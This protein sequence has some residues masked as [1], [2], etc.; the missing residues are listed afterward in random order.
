MIYQSHNYQKRRNAFVMLLF[1]LVMPC[2]IGMLALIVDGGLAMNNQRRLQNVA[3][4]I[5]TSVANRYVRGST[6]AQCIAAANE[7]RSV[8]YPNSNTFAWNA[9]TNN[10]VNN[11]PISGPY[12]GNAKFIEVVVTA[13]YPGIL[14]SIFSRTASTIKARAV[15][16]MESHVTGEGVITLDPCLRPGLEV[17][18]GS[19]LIVAGA[20][21]CNSG[22][23]GYDQNN[24][25]TDLG[26][27]QYSASVA[28]NGTMKCELAL[29][30]G[31]V[32]T[33]SNFQNYTD[34]APNPLYANIRSI[35]PDPYRLLPIPKPANTPSITNWNTSKKVA[36]STGQTATLTPGIYEDISITGSANVTFSPGTYIMV[37]KTPNQGLRINGSPTV[38]G[39]NVFFYFT[40]SNYL[41]TSPGYWDTL[42]GPVD[43]PL[44]PSNSAGCSLPASPDNLKNVN[45][46]TL[47]INL[48]SGSVNFT[49]CTDTGSPFHNFLFFQRRRNSNNAQIQANAGSQV[50]MK[51]SIY[52]KWSWFKVAGAGVY[53]SQ[54]TVGTMTVTGGGQVIIEKYDRNFNMAGFIYLVE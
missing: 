18:G 25:W 1:G 17:S 24:Y 13:P 23:A 50:F 15:A 43:G 35:F 30:R 34:G 20:V 8:S 19:Q 14:S 10:S 36:Y 2:I 51:G 4:S 9:G 53:Q 42:D 22:G 38:I 26:I 11:P 48:N 16:G 31:G 40:G 12:A 28:N 21:I 45:F 7:I 39:N 46:A 37:P 47:D 44:P 5:A 49:G 32:D 27:Q 33:V 52:A 6:S 54:F 29:V 41:N 3:D